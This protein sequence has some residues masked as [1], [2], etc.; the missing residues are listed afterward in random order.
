[1]TDRK[2]RADAELDSLVALAVGIH[3]GNPDE[4]LDTVAR[5]HQNQAVTSAQLPVMGTPGHY[6]YSR[7]DN[8]QNDRAWEEMGI[9]FGEVTPG[10]LFRD[11]KLPPGWLVRR[12]DHMLW[13]EVV[14]ARGR[15]RASFFYKGAAWDRDAFINLRH[16]FKVSSIYH[17]VRQ[18]QQVAV[19]DGKEARYQTRIVDLG[20]E[21]SHNEDQEA[22][23]AWVKKREAVTTELRA[24]CEKWLDERYPDWRHPWAHWNDDE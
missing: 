15:V 14:D 24:E 1:M 10:E 7:E 23:S 11:A 4:G 5:M 8:S 20:P 21:P 2:V 17:D 6:R 12:T 9:E 22:W 18:L 3:T 16:R 13:N 19:L